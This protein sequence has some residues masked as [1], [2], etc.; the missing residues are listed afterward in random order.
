MNPH[1]NMRKLI[2]LVESA[3]EPGLNDYSREDDDRREHPFA[4]QLTQRNS[5]QDRDSDDE[6][7]EGSIDN[8]NGDL[9]R[10]F[11]Q[12]ENRYI[13]TRRL[14]GLINKDKIEY[15]PVNK[16]ALLRQ[17]QQKS[18]VMGMMNSMRAEMNKIM[19]QLGWSA[20]EVAYHKSR[21]DGDREFG[22]PSE[23]FTHQRP[24]VKI[25]VPPR[26][27]P[28]KAAEPKFSW[29]DKFKQSMAKLREPAMQE[30]SGQVSTTLKTIPEIVERERA[31]LH[32]LF[33][34][35]LPE[36]YN[37]EWAEYEA[38]WGG[39]FSYNEVAAQEWKAVLDD[40]ECHAL[41]QAIDKKYGTELVVGIQDT[42][43]SIAG[44]QGL[45]EAEK[46]SGTPNFYD[47]N[48]PEFKPAPDGKIHLENYGKW[49]YILQKYY[50]DVFERNGE[51]NRA[52]Y[53]NTYLEGVDRICRIGS[54][55][56][57]AYYSQGLGWVEVPVTNVDEAKK[58]SKPP[59]DDAT[60]KQLEDPIWSTWQAIASDLQ[61]AYEFSG[62]EM[63]NLGAIEGCIDSDRLRC[64]GDPGNHASVMRG[65][66]VGNAAQDLVRALVMAHGYPTVLKWLGSKIQLV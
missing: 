54:N 4:S 3:Q 28:A 41:L 18:E 43:D 39:D 40:P 11:D 32:D 23:I 10:R 22:K 24:E 5:D 52:K 31:R 25:P 35:G 30:A 37:G 13:K 59:L 56:P 62:E 16:D 61:Q 7:E 53:R 34:N 42:I 44:D 49:E 19:G 58:S 20:E 64:Y 38:D 36:V 45:D 15:S 26:E 48:E 21:M 63:D 9:E 17:K 33:N 57:I 51:I 2:N 6:L 1:D 46:N 50:P 65:S 14:L 55:D 12:L 8:H 27:E 66:P 29:Y 47:G 60:W